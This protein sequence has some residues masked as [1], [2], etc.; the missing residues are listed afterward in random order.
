MPHDPT[1]PG[2]HDL[3]QLAP[4]P[5]TS[6]VPEAVSAATPKR[7]ARRR[8]EWVDIAKGTSIILVVILHSANLLVSKGLAPEVWYTINSYL[9][10]VRMP[11]FFVASGLFAQGMV[12][13][14]WPRMLRSRIAHLMYLYT[15]W[16]VIFLG[17]HNVLPSDVRHEGYASWMNVVGGL[18]MPNSALWFIYGLAVFAV[19]A[20]AMTRLPLWVQLGAAVALNV[21]S[22]YQPVVSWSWNNLAEYFIY[23]LLGLHARSLIITVSRRTALP[24]IAASIAAYAAMYS[25]LADADAGAQGLTIVLTTFGLAAG[26]LVSAAVVG[27]PVGEVLNKVGRTTLPVYLMLDM[28]IALLGYVVIKL[29]IINELLVVQAIAPLAVA[30][31]T[32]VLALYAHKILLALRLNWLFELPP[33]LRGTAIRKP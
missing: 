7:S 24:W 26:V 16:L 25:M 32:V 5:M 13:M 10:P 18:Y 12:A 30:A 9:Q 23:F 31:G 3:A 14:A 22:Q 15:L 27:T 6:P 20:K 11:L 19:A 28:F 4:A 29:S 1:A 8:I 33:R 2:T 17:V 21:Y